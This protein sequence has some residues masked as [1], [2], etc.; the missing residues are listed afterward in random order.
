[1]QKNPIIVENIYETTHL[2][3]VHSLFKIW[4]LRFI[5]ILITHHLNI[6]LNINKIAL[7]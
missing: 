7:Y 1:M 5:I 4:A 2:N 3:A 6:E